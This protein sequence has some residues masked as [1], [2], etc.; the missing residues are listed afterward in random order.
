MCVNG[1]AVDNKILDKMTYLGYLEC[2]MACSREMRKYQMRF[3]FHLVE[4]LQGDQKDFLCLS[5]RA[6]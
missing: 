1:V 3:Y 5:F 4:K 6:S 2:S